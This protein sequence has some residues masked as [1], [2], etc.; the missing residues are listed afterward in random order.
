MS[1]LMGLPVLVTLLAVTGGLALCA[2]SA[3]A[4]Q[5]GKKNKQALNLNMKQERT[6]NYPVEVYDVE[7]LH[8]KT[9]KHK[10]TRDPGALWQRSMKVLKE[11]KFSISMVCY[12]HY[13]L[14]VEVPV[15]VIVYFLE[16]LYGLTDEW[17]MTS[18]CLSSML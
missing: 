7:R 16:E 12:F 8:E 9:R 2:Q 6:Y 11:T 3:T 18:A 10:Q 5:P 17:Q 4:Y 15:T 13:C 1:F 14:T